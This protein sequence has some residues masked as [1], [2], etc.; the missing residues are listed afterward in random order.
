MDGQEAGQAM[1]RD[2]PCTPSERTLNGLPQR[3]FA[4]VLAV[5]LVA[6]LV[7]AGVPITA[8]VLRAFT[9][10]LLLAVST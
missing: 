7:F 9:W 10:A 5:V 4:N 6:M 2:I 3:V 8:P 1:R